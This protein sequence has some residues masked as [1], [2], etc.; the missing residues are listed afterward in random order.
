MELDTN[1]FGP[2]YSKEKD[3]KRIAKQ[4][5]AI[6][7]YMLSVGWKTLAEIE[8]ALGYPQA[9]ISAQLRHLRKE[10]FG[11]YQVDKQRTKPKGGTWMYRVRKP[12]QEQLFGHERTW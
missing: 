10:R 11:S 7:D 1:T 6:K 5:D 9:S 3:G 12:F 8:E 4:I 2:A